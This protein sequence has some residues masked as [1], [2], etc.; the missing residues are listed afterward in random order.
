MLAWPDLIII[1]LVKSDKPKGKTLS[2]TEAARN[3]AD[4]LSRIEYRGERFV[5]YRKGRPVAELGPAGPQQLSGAD[6]LAALDALPHPDPG[7]ADA[8]EEAIAGQGTL[9]GDPWA[10]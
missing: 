4:L 6:W 5:V 7:W 2:A 3:F 10:S 8:V 9:P 1:F